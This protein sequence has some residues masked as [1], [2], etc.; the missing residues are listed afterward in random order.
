M[1]NLHETIEKLKK[2]CDALLPQ[3]LNAKF[4]GQQ[5]LSVSKRYRVVQS[6]GCQLSRPSTHAPFPTR[7]SR[8]PSLSQ[9]IQ[10]CVLLPP[11]HT[12]PG[13]RSRSEN[14]P[15]RAPDLGLLLQTLAKPEYKN[16]DENHKMK[17]IELQTT[18]CAQ[19]D[20]ENP[21][22]ALSTAFSLS[23]DLGSG[24]SGADA[25]PRDQDGRDQQVCERDL[26]G[27]VQG[28]RH[29]HDPDQGAPPLTLSVTPR[30]SQKRRRGAV[31]GGGGSWAGSGCAVVTRVVGTG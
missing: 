16:I 17:S 20:L 23:S 30:D 24:A 13:R 28:R 31:I 15:W 22:I 7:L 6:Q 9:F 14:A 12:P 27:D 5:P 8:I 10:C 25:V 21:R 1:D 3:C 19:K 2:V 26:A 4:E 11:P 18:K 29:R